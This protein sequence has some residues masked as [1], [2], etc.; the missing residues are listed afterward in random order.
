MAHENLTVIDLCCQLHT[1]VISININVVI[2]NLGSLLIAE[3]ARSQP[4]LYKQL[5][6]TSQSLYLT[7]QTGDGQTDS[8]MYQCEVDVDMLNA[9]KRNSGHFYGVQ[10][11]HINLTLIHPALYCYADAD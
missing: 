2:L 3:T 4:H 5:V 10:H 7:R 9:V 1:G 8:R 6:S 11:I